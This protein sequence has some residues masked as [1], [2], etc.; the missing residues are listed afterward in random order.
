MTLLK[1]LPG[2]VNAHLHSPYGPQYRG[3]T[4]SRPFEAWMGDV[5]ARETRP[6]TPDEVGACALVTGLE[7]LATGSTA[8][9]D[10]YF[11]LPTAAHIYAIAQAYEDLGLRAWVFTSLG[12]LPYLHYTREGFPHYADAIPASA[13]PADL[14]QWALPLPH[15]EDQ[16]NAAAETIRGWHGSRVRIGLGLSNPVWCSDGLLRGAA[17]LARELDVPIEIH[18]EESPVQRRVSLGEWGLSGIQRLDRLG[19]LSERTLL[20]HVVQVDEADIALVARSRAS[21]SHNPVSNLK[22]QVGVAP[23]GRLVAAGVNVC[24]GSDGQAS[25]DSQNLFTVLKFVAALAGQ[26]GLRALGGVVEELALKLAV[27]NGRRLWFEGDLSRDYIEFDEPLGPY[28]YAWDDPAMHIAEVYVDG[29][30]RLAEARRL[31]R[32]RGADRLMI[33]LRQALVAPDRLA[34]AE[35]WAESTSISS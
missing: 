10:Q 20:A 22:L 7:N 12:D 27:D 19:L 24:L 29:Q 18:A 4:R 8:L 1:T 9:V 35:R 16:L 21:V 25:A 2:L 30:P 3:V 34:Q 33:E 26:N 17:R 31:V 28:S 14:Q 13:V 23:V 6:A 11:G 32:E 15:Y 5:M